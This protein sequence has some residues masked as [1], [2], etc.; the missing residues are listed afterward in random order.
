MLALCQAIKPPFRLAT[1]SKPFLRN[2]PHIE[3]E[4][5]PLLQLTMT[6]DDL[7]LLSFVIFCFT[8]TVV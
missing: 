2:N 8:F 6:G 5:A 4:R 1:F 3:L 7:S